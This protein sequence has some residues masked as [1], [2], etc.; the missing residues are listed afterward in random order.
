MSKRRGVSLVET[1]VAAVLLMIGIAGTLHALGA[2]A[3]LR[4]DAEARD[5]LTGLLL[6]RL[7]WFEA[8]ACAGGDTSGVTR[9]ATGPQLHWRVEVVGATR[10]LRL[11]AA[12]SAAPSGLG[13]RT[14]VETSRACD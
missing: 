4:H 10:R 13:S 6:D 2:S 1:L 5:V 7:A 3:R 8:R 14:R 12:R 11:H 9:N